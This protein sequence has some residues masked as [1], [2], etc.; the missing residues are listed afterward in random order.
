MVGHDRINRCRAAHQAFVHRIQDIAVIGI[1]RPCKETAQVIRQHILTFCGS[2]TRVFIRDQVTGGFV[3]HIRRFSCCI[4]TGFPAWLTFVFI[5]DLTVVNY[6]WFPGAFHHARCRTGEWIVTSV[7][8][9][10]GP[11]AAIHTRA[12]NDLTRLN[13]L[14]QQRVHAVFGGVVGVWF[15]GC[16]TQR[17]LVAQLGIAPAAEEVIAHQEDV[18]E[19]ALR[20]GVIHVFN[21]IFAGTNG[22]GQFIS[23]TGLCRQ[24]VQHDTQIVDHCGIGGFILLRIAQGFRHTAAAREFPVDIHAVEEFPG[25]QELFN[26][27]DKTCADCSIAHMIER[28]G[29]RPAADGWQYLQVRMRFFQRHQLTKVTLVRVVPARNASL[30][31]LQCSP[32]IVDCHGEIRAALTVALENFEAVTAFNGFQ[33]IVDAIA[34]ADWN[35]AIQNMVKVCCRDFVYREVT[36]IYAPFREIGCNHFVGVLS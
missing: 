18:V 16:P 3:E 11:A 10:A 35:E 29:Q 30:W 1:D 2:R 23:T 36:A 17:S 7:A 19:I 12:H 14:L 27:G 15:P 8:V 28:I 24:F 26:R 33:T 4:V 13:T 6:A 22:A 5:H 20:R 31:L 9:N 21:F 32:R 25:L 34:A